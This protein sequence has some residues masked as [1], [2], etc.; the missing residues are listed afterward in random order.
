M[1]FSEVVTL[2]E[3][4]NMHIPHKNLFFNLSRY[5]VSSIHQDNIPTIT[6][7]NKEYN[8]SFIEV[9]HPS[10]VD[11]FDTL[12][13]QKSAYIMDIYKFDNMGPDFHLK[14]SVYMIQ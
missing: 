8:G 5:G 6:I 3:R 13:M 12:N 7:N 14:L 1:Q 2:I 9:I 4:Y 11:Y 10:W